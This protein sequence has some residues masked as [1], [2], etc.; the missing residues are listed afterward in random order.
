M[1][2]TSACWLET[3]KSGAAAVT[4]CITYIV[5]VASCSAADK[6]SLSFASMRIIET[7]F[8]FVEVENRCAYVPAGMTI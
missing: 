5:V 3:V 7:V 8:M 2:L 4:L 6:E 1:V